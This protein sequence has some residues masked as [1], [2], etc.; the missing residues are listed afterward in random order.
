MTP[1]AESQHQIEA[2]EDGGGYARNSARFR[3]A[4]TIQQ[5]AFDRCDPATF[6]RHLF[7]EPLFEG[8]ETNTLFLNAIGDGTVPVSTNAVLGLIAGVFGDTRAEWEPRME[9]L[10]DSGVMEGALYD[11]HDIRGDNPEGMPAI[12]LYEPV[13]TGRGV[14]S[15]RLADVNGKHEWI[16]GYEKDEFQFGRYSQHQ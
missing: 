9:A 16:A 2:I 11:V 13:S 7:K 5:H 4:A 15:I 14:A 12:E 6:A 1:G 3:R 10:I 8:R